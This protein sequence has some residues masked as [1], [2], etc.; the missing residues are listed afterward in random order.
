M[1]L[2]NVLKTVNQ[3]ILPKNHPKISSCQSEALDTR[4]LL[5]YCHSLEG[6]A[7]IQSKPNFQAR[8]RAVKL[9]KERP[10]ASSQV[11]RQVNY[12]ININAVHRVC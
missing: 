10:N 9:N 11:T 8:G 5:R 4:A 3:E 7:E 12:H 2:S 1:A 6:T